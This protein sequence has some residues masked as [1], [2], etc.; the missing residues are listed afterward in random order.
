MLDGYS[1]PVASLGGFNGE[2][3][4]NFSGKPSPGCSRRGAKNTCRGVTSLFGRFS[5][6]PRSEIDPPT[7]VPP[8]QLQTRELQLE[9]SHFLSIR[10]REIY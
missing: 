4:G 3:L 9:I 5:Y 8:R 7:T 10:A 2:D 6:P 1:G